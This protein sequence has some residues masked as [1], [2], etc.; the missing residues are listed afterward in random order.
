MAN[1]LFNMPNRKDIEKNEIICRACGR[2]IKKYEE[3]CEIKGITYCPECV[4]KGKRYAI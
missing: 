4:K 2:R 1:G 3:Y